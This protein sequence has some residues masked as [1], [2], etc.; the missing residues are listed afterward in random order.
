MNRYLIIFLQPYDHLILREPAH[1]A[2]CQQF[3]GLDALELLLNNETLNLARFHDLAESIQNSQLRNDELFQNYLNKYPAIM[4]C[5]DQY[6]YTLKV[7]LII[8]SARSTYLRLKNRMIESGNLL[9]E[10]NILKK[11]IFAIRSYRIL[12]FLSQIKKKLNEFQIVSAICHRTSLRDFMLLSIF[13]EY[14]AIK[15]PF[16]PDIEELLQKTDKFEKMMNETCAYC[17]MPVD[18]TTGM[19][20][21]NHD[22]PR[23]CFS[24][25]QVPIM[26][27]RQCTRCHIFAL[28]DISQLNQILPISFQIKDDIHCPLCDLPFDIPHSVYSDFPE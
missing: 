23:C 18:Q 9:G 25:I 4:E 24:S 7:R 20:D 16:H 26:N 14:E 2:I 15:I 13:D 17:E 5:S 21:D 1:I 27:Q 10:Y 6:I 28:D 3:N 22:F 12:S 8:T 11:I 19:C